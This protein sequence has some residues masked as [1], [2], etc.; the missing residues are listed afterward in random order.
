MGIRGK[1]AGNE[2]NSK[3]KEKQKEKPSKKSWGKKE[4]DLEGDIKN[5][6]EML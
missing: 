2:K 5:H 1:A 6:E 3:F 4:K